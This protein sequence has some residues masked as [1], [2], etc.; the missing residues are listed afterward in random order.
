MSVI[1]VEG[2]CT[3]IRRKNNSCLQ[4][5]QHIAAARARSELR[6]ATQPG[7]CL[8]LL[9]GR[10]R[11][12]LVLLQCRLPGYRQ[13][14]AAQSPCA[15]DLVVLAK[16]RPGQAFRVVGEK[17]PVA[18]PA[19]EVDRRVTPALR[20]TGALGITG[21]AVGRVGIGQTEA[22]DTFLAT[23]QHAMQ[24]GQILTVLDGMAG[25]AQNLFN[26]IVRKGFQPQLLDL[27]ELLGVGVGRVILVVVV[28]PKQGKDL[29]DGFD[30]GVAGRPTAGISRPRRCR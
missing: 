17:E 22:G 14:L 1:I 30:M 6:F 20:R 19:G 8:E 12:R 24:R 18:V 2:K 29:V 16:H 27:L 13:R 11:R 5:R 9:C 7:E 23:L 10:Q 25:A 3:G 28:Q 21:L 26:R 15:P 4:T